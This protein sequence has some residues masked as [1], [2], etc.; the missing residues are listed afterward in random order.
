MFRAAPRKK[1]LFAVLG[2][3][4]GHDPIEALGRQI[5]CPESRRRAIETDVVSSPAK[6][7]IS[8]ALRP[9]CQSRGAVGLRQRKDKCKLKKLSQR[10]QV[11]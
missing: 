2:S 5:R 11:A 3:T 7:G 4:A 1:R 9:L 8:R 10:S 6:T